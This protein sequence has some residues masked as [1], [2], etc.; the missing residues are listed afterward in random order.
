MGFVSIQS[1]RF[2]SGLGALSARSGFG[3]GLGVHMLSAIVW[4]WCGLGVGFVSVQLGLV[5]VR[6]GLGRPNKATLVAVDT[7]NLA[8]ISQPSTR[9]IAR[10]LSTHFGYPIRRLRPHK[11]STICPSASAPN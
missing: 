4:V 1:A 7:R 5:W 2:L 8:Q 6:S 3:V 10:F 11:D 9:N